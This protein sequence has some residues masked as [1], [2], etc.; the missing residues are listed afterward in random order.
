M[1]RSLGDLSFIFL[2][3]FLGRPGDWQPVINS[4]TGLTQS[5]CNAIDYFA[6]PPISPKNP[7]ANW[8]LNFAQWIRINLGPGPHCLVGYSLGGRLTLHAL[9]AHPDLFNIG[10]CISTNPGVFLGGSDERTQKQT[11]DEKWAQRFLRDPWKDLMK[12]G[13]FNQTFMVGDEFAKWV[14]GEDKRH[15][16]LMKEAGFLAN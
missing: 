13:A 1:G 11:S 10:V 15:Q 12:D 7:L 8:T 14:D 3:G 9:E 4:L 5:K 6:L 16:T 2:H